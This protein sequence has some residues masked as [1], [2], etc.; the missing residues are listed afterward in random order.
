MAGTQSAHDR[1]RVM[2]LVDL[3]TP[4]ARAA[5]TNATRST[6]AACLRRAAFCHIAAG[7]GRVFR[8]G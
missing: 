7:A 1:F 4:A 3:L 5:A 8:A 2:E 6:A